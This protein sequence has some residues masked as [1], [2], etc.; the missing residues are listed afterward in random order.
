MA[1]ARDLPGWPKKRLVKEVR[2][3]L[4][5]YGI[6]SQYEPW[7]LTWAWT[8]A[9][10]NSYVYSHWPSPRGIATQYLLL[11][12]SRMK[13]DHNLKL[14]YRADTVITQAVRQALPLGQTDA[15]SLR[16]LL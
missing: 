1:E 2:R 14:P 6:R 15:E 12:L 3:H 9:I 7:K 8:S 13:Q 11:L 16:R 4:W 10:A 5:R